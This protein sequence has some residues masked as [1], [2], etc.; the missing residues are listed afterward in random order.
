MTDE[1]DR[2]IRELRFRVEQL[3]ESIYTCHGIIALLVDRLGG[4]VSFNGGIDCSMAPYVIDRDEGG[5]VRI[6]TTK[7]EA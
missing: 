3:S 2:T 5:E 4:K 1:R 7:R 6:T